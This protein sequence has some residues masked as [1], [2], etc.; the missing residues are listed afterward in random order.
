MKRYLP[1]KYNGA[2]SLFDAFDNFFKPVFFD[3]SR[4]MR[5]DIS[6]TDEGYKLEIEMPGFKKN[7]INVSL[8]DGY[9][10]VSGCK[11]V[12][13]EEKDKHG[14]RYLRKERSASFQRSY[15][16][17]TEIPENSIKAKYEDGI[18]CLTVPKSQPKQITK[19]SIEIE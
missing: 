11:K 10:T 12:S 15:Y 18:L 16:V 13:S 8:D 5:T 2:E 1:E 3:E 14:D 9:I 7:E 19:H 6:E 4:D 17:G